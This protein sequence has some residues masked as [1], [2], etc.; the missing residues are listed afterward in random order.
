MPAFG[1]IRLFILSRRIPEPCQ[2]DDC[3]HN[4]NAAV[5][6]KSPPPAHPMNQPGH[7]EKSRCRTNPATGMKYA[8]S[9]PSFFCIDPIKDGSRGAGESASFSRSKKEPSN[10]HGTR[11][12]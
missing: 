12:P 6:E 10:E 4:P 7:Q 11:I 2:P 3:P 5:D 1:L 9:Q 8:I